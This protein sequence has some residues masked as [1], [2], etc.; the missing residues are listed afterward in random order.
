MWECLNFDEDASIVNKN[1]CLSYG[2]VWIQ[3]KL[4]ASNF[5]NALLYIF[6]VSS[7]EDWLSAMNYLST[8]QGPNMQPVLINSNLIRILFLVFI[9]FANIIVMNIFVGVCIN[10]FKQISKKVT[11]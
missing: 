9:F 11:G 7:T 3:E 4:N 10:N 8:I 6:L 1:D 5:L 2:G